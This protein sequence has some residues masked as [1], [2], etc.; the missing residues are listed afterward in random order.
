MFGDVWFECCQ[1]R[2]IEGGGV[3][4]FGDVW[5]ECWQVS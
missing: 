5:F 1:V 2:V 3:A 4:V